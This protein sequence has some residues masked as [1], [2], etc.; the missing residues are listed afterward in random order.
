MVLPWLR[1]KN[2]F[3]LRVYNWNVMHKISWKHI[4][5]DSDRCRSYNN[6]LIQS[7]NHRLYNL[8]NLISKEKSSELN[9]QM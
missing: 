9:N 1:C 6:A 5:A 4:C 8:E 3:I 2:P 7:L